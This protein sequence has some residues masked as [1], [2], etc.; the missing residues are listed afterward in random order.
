MSLSS[1]RLNGS[2]ECCG[3]MKERIWA[4]KVQRNIPPALRGYSPEQSTANFIKHASQP[5]LGHSI[6]LIA[7]D[8]LLIIVS[9]F[10][11][12]AGWKSGL[13]WP[14]LLVCPCTMV[15]AGRA[16]RG[17]ECLVHEASHFN[18]SRNRPLNDRLADYLCAWPVLSQVAK[19]RRSHLVHHRSF[20]HAT[21][22]DRIRHERLELA[23][24]DRSNTWRFAPGIMARLLPY[25]PGW[26]WAIGVDLGTVVH[27]FFWHT[28]C[29]LLPS[30]LFLGLESALSLWI[31]TWA[32]PVFVVLPILRFVGEAAEHDYGD[33]RDAQVIFK[34]TWSNIGWLHRWVFHPHNDGFHAVHHL[35]PSVPCHALPIVHSQL[36]DQDPSFSSNALMRTA[37]TGPDA[38]REESK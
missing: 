25:I 38:F 7:I 2:Q 35:Y 16:M 32:L 14:F 28:F 15:V 31:L 9:G 11:S 27:F 13:I 1:L 8:H 5:K 33:I 4:P 19:Y 37:L 3:A 21:D 20:G 26:W 18:L 24:L 22:P 17:L 36:M 10:I 12:Y 6:M 23:K 34:S 30:T 29:F